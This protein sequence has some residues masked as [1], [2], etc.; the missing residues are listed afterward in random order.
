MLASHFLAVAQSGVTPK[1]TTIYFS[2]GT[3]TAVVFMEGSLDGVNTFTY[4]DSQAFQPMR[5]LT[6]ANEGQTRVIKPR[7]VVNGK[8]NWYDIESIRAEVF[9]GATTV[10]ERALAVWKFMRDNRLH[11]YE[12]AYGREVDDAVKFLGVYGYGMCYNTSFVGA[13]I[14]SGLL[15][16]GKAYFEYSPRNRHSVKEIVFDTTAVLLDPDIEVFYLK[17]DN[18]TLASYEDVAYD[19]YLITRTH[20]YGKAVPYNTLNNYVADAVYEPTPPMKYA[21]LYPDYHTLDLNL[22]PGEMLEYSWAP[23]AYYHHFLPWDGIHNVPARNIRNGRIV[24]RTNFTNAPLDE[25]IDSHSGL[26]TSSD[27]PS[28]PNVHP[29]DTGVNSSMVIKVESPFVIVNGTIQGSFYRGNDDEISLSVSR[30]SVSWTT[31]WKDS[32]TGVHEDSISLLDFIDPLASEAV[33]SYYVRIDM[34]AAGSDL[35][36][37]DSLSITS[38]FQVSRFFLP[39]LELGDNIIAYSDSTKGERNVAVTIEWQESE[40]NLPPSR[41]EQ[42]VFPA[43]GA[44]VD[45]LKFTFEWS[46][47]VDPDGI[48]DYEFVLSDREDMRFPLSPSFEVYT[49]HASGGQGTARFSI[50]FDG[51]LNSDSTYYWRVRAK[52]SKGAWGEWSPVWSFIPKGPMPPVMQE[53]VIQ[54][55]S[56]LLQWEA[57]G[58]GSEPAFYEIHASNEAYG[59]TPETSTLLD[60]TR[61]TGMAVRIGDKA[62]LTFY[63]VVAVDHNG[64][65]SEPSNY[66]M[67]PYPHV[68]SQPDS[69]KPGQPFEVKL[70]TNSVYTT[71]MMLTWLL[72]IR[73][74]DSVNVSLVSK[75]E[76]ITYNAD[77]QTLMG[78]PSYA[79]AHK[80]SIVVEFTGV[81]T[82][83][84][85]VQVFKPSVIPNG[86]PALSNIDSLAYVGS[87]F[88]QSIVASDPDLP[89]GDFIDRIEVVAKPVW[90][91]TA[92]GE[93]DATLTVWG[94]P[95][96]VDAADTIL[97]VRAFDSLNDST[98][99]TYVI[100]IRFPD[101]NGS[102]RGGIVTLAPNPFRQEISVAYELLRP[103]EVQLTIYN[104]SAQK[105]YSTSFTDNE[106]GTHIKYINPGIGQNG[107]YYLVLEIF[108][109]D[110]RT[111]GT[112]RRIVRLE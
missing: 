61:S 104:S 80:D 74:E 52:D 41:V 5:K 95:E 86:A 7:L 42:P 29:L 63:R 8:R 64:S 48:I 65:R 21:G 24:Y 109:D 57:N 36:G 84:R 106:A 62:P 25:L 35:C 79:E 77:D 3:D 22:R 23:G 44:M 39:E 26:T 91:E 17:R 103:G 30:D 14:A 112:T 101:Q 31:V 108:E 54:G 75:P 47:A 102:D 90:L 11:Y 34:L 9:D 88:K 16:E 76:W 27:D 83:Y 19:K 55:D 67:I 12:P 46:P 66:T 99:K 71:D 40:E 81:S 1:S 20:H 18:S 72:P 38:N 10:K 93:G 50:P 28:E 97:V 53:A 92:Y 89:R 69:I 70:T 78:L 107:L 82:G 68:Y 6:I 45:S 100:R 51:M 98:E 87:E 15:K 43:D 13:S 56:I 105:V 73:I 60:T 59:F 4:P 33:Y 49:S 32:K 96:L 94:T 58:G 37:V 110:G 85:N 2:E 111:H